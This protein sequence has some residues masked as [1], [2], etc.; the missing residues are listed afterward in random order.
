MNNKKKYYY[1]FLF[2]IALFT[3]FRLWLANYLGLG[4]DEAYYWEWSRHI[5]AGYFDHPPL[6]GY[7]IYFSTFILGKSELAVRIGNII[8]FVL[9]SYFVYKISFEMFKDEECSFYSSLLLNITPVFAAGAFMAF[10]DTPLGFFWVAVIFV[11]SRIITTKK[12]WLWYPAGILVGLGL[13]SKYNAVLLP[14]SILFFLIVSKEHRFWLKEKEPY[15]ASILALITFLPVIL[16]NIENGWASFGFQLTHGLT[17]KSSGFDFKNTIFLISSQ[18]TYISPLIF[19]FSWYAIFITFRKGLKENTNY[20]LLSCF[21]IPTMLLFNIAG[22]FKRTMPHWTALGF[23]SMFIAIPQLVKEM[24]HENAGR[25]IKKF[26]IITIGL[27][28][29]LTALITIQTLY[30]LLPLKPR[31]DVTN[32]LYGWQKAAAKANDIMNE[33]IKDN[34]TFWLTHFHLVASQLAFYLKGDETVYNLSKRISQ[35]NF[36]F[37]SNN[38][39]KLTG[40]NAVYINTSHYNEEPE[41]FFIFDSAHLEETIE[42]Y[43]AEK[44][45]RFFNIYK[46]YNFKGMK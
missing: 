10:P 18:L 21:S 5:A 9:T 13:L 37:D 34:N 7:I 39:K 45:S 11:F 2:L 42:I 36:W 20:L 35:Y 8:F 19:I 16:W 41:D 40:K 26:S 23:I 22:I 17:S 25:G 38:I 27:A 15:L 44:I 4:D 3:I 6:I 33:M 12:K 31:H 46:V 32:D 28:V 24:K 14:I 30:P 29:M 1:Y 43:R